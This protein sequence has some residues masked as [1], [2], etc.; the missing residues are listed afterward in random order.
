MGNEIAALLAKA[1]AIEQARVVDRGQVS[2]VDLAELL[3][4]V[5]DNP[6]A[7]PEAELRAAFE[8]MEALAVAAWERH[9]L[10]D[11]SLGRGPAPDERVTAYVI[12]FAD[13]RVDKQRSTWQNS[14]RAERWDP[15]RPKV[16][17]VKAAEEAVA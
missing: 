9:R 8:A 13:G 4:A 10:G 12:A 2:G 5:G 6:L 1:A 14:R 15:N 3:A 7:P 17:P 16:A 11:F